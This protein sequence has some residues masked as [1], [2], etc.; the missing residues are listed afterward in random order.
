MNR[1]SLLA[2]SGDSS[3]WLTVGLPVLIV[4]LSQLGAFGVAWVT[5]ERRHRA[6]T[7]SFLRTELRHV[8]TAHIAAASRYRAEASAL[9]MAVAMPGLAEL[10][11]E[12]AWRNATAALGEYQVANSEA[13]LLA[14][15]AYITA[16]DI[17]DE[18]LG[19]LI[20][21]ALDIDEVP[22]EERPLVL[23]RFMEVDTMIA[24]LREIAR[25]DVRA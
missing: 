4:L 8:Y 3:F 14:S 15:D 21:R 23:A 7:K 10:T 2:A 1:P 9:M 11:D 22:R 16:A 17:V 25:R 24:E 5:A 13:R 18:E 20:K 6:E 12:E 19:A